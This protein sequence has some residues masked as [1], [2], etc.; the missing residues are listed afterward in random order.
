[1]KTFLPQDIYAQIRSMIVG[2]ATFNITIHGLKFYVNHPIA[3]LRGRDFHHNEPDMIYWLDT[4][5]D[6]NS[7]LYD[8]GANVGTYSLY[9]AQQRGAHVVAFEPA[10]G[11]F[12]VLNR[13]ITLN[14]LEDHICG[15]SLAMHDK[16]GIDIFNLSKLDPGGAIHSVGN[17]KAGSDGETFEAVSSQSVLVMR[18][19]DFIST[20]NMQVP[21]HLKID[22][23]GNDRLVLDGL[24]AILK[25]PTLRYIA[26]EVNEGIR[27]G[28]NDVNAF[29]NTFGFD[30]LTDI[31]LQNP[32]NLKRGKSYNAYFARRM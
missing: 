17:T 27:E 1:M 12:D 7:T 23:D 10:P 16:T 25:N 5:V 31:N 18:L 13:N 9:A 26:I 22:V 19:D 28:D 30:R 11:N 14:G 3:Y 29:L 15:F 24:G 21:T 4:F 32:N 8:V 2:L 20:F 6:A